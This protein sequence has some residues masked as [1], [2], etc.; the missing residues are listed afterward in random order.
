[1]H[2]DVGLEIA[3]EIS[4]TDQHSRCALGYIQSLRTCAPG[5]DSQDTVETGSSGV[6]NGLVPPLSTPKKT[7]VLVARR[8]LIHTAEGS[9]WRARSARGQAGTALPT[10]EITGSIPL[11]ATAGKVALVRSTTALSG[12]RPTTNVVDFV[13][14]QQP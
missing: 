14:Y 8:A 1:M 12:T 3:D 7:P 6:K 11:S 13:G 5:I 10:P 2:L 4:G 9:A